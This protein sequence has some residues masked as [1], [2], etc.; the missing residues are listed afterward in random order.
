MAN[1]GAAMLGVRIWP[2]PFSVDDVNIIGTQST[3]R[4]VNVPFYLVGQ[5]DKIINGL[6]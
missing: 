5:L 1:D 6:I 2:G 4:L 3:Y